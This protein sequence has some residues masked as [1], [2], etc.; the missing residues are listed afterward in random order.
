MHGAF[1]INSP[2]LRMDEMNTFYRQI[3]RSTCAWSSL[4]MSESCLFFRAS[5][6]PSY[7]IFILALEQSVRWNEGP[8]QSAALHTWIIDA[9]YKLLFSVSLLVCGFMPPAGS[10]VWFFRAVFRAR[11]WF[12]LARRKTSMENCRTVF[13]VKWV[14]VNTVMKG[15]I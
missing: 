15:I 5:S 11:E 14:W 10:G 3:F 9:G 2:C 4:Q 7:E 1:L 8:H 13:L 6:A 12:F